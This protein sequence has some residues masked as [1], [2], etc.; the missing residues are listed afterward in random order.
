MT[1]RIGTGVPPQASRTIAFTQ[2]GDGKGGSVL[3]LQTGIFALVPEQIN[4]LKNQTWDPDLG[5]SL[6]LGF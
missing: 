1:G 6:K 3:K 5:N 2:R 4:F